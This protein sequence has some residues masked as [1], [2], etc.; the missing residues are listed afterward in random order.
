MIEGRKVNWRAITAAQ[1]VGGLAPLPRGDQ[2]RF[3]TDPIT[4]VVPLQPAGVSPVLT[5]EQKIQRENPDPPS[6]NFNDANYLPVSAIGTPP[7]DQTCNAC[8][9]IPEEIP[10][11]DSASIIPMCKLNMLM[12][13]WATPFGQ[14]WITIPASTNGELTEV[15]AYADWDTFP[16]Y[17]DDVYP[18]WN[19]AHRN[20]LVGCCYQILSPAL[21]VQSPGGNAAPVQFPVAPTPEQAAP[22]CIPYPITRNNIPFRAHGYIKIRMNNWGSMLDNNIVLGQD[23]RFMFAQTNYITASYY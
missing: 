7:L 13:Q 20:E 16:R 1:Q 2:I 6:I 3:I 21:P 14:T 23:N 15:L 9:V 19:D 5:T 22:Q 8:P 4:A 18:N 17:W 12:N 10:T 11:I